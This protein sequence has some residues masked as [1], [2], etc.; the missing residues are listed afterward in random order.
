MHANVASPTLSRRKGSGGGLGSLGG[1]ELALDTWPRREV[2]MPGT[3][4]VPDLNRLSLS[5]FILWIQRCGSTDVG[6]MGA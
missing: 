3:T 4:G 1:F 5:A 6:V 2:Q